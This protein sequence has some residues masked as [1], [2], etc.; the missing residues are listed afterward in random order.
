MRK[1]DAQMFIRR[2]ACSL[3]GSNSDAIEQTRCGPTAGRD[4]G[5]R[6]DLR[7][8]RLLALGRLGGGKLR[9]SP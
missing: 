6:P 7:R 1:D 8:T 2:P 3:A 5:R 9:C 4:S